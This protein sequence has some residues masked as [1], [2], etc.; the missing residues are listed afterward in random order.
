MTTDVFGSSMTSP[1]KTPEIWPAP[2][3]PQRSLKDCPDIYV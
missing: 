2:R 3:I 1:T